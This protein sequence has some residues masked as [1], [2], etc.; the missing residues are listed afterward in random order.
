MGRA[1]FQAPDYFQGALESAGWPRVGMK[2]SPGLNSLWISKWH[3]FLLGGK[4]S[5]VCLRGPQSRALGHQA[6]GEGRLKTHLWVRFMVEGHIFH[7]SSNCNS[8]LPPVEGILTASPSHTLHSVYPLYPLLG[9][10][11]GMVSRVLPT[12]AQHCFPC[13]KLN[14]LIFQHLLHWR[15]A[16]PPVVER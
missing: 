6:S 14:Y 8:A 16:P 7:L 9:S 10:S 1:E 2:I 3:G 4:Q 13:G 11:S 5:P 12:A 15:S